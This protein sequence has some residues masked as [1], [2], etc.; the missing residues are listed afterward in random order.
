MSKRFCGAGDG[1]LGC[2]ARARALGFIVVACHDDMK[3]PFIPLLLLRPPFLRTAFHGIVPVWAGRA[4]FFHM[5]MVRVFAT[6][7]KAFVAKYKSLLLD[8]MR[9]RVLI[10][11]TTHQQPH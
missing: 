2:F 6:R 1:F 4:T 10:S 3:L 9:Q 5:D 8:Q 7:D 11:P